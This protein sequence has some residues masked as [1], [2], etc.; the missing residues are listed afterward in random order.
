MRLLYIICIILHHR[1][2]IY[3]YIYFG[4]EMCNCVC[5][6]VQPRP[7]YHAHTPT[8]TD[9]C[10]HN[11]QLYMHIVKGGHQ[12]VTSL[13]RYFVIP[14]LCYSVTPLL[15]YSVTAL[16]R[17]SVTHEVIFLSND[18]TDRYFLFSVTDRVTEVT[19]LVRYSAT[20]CS[21]TPLLHYFVTQLT[22]FIVLIFF[23]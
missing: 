6:F 7:L 12:S 4:M 10:T 17:Y 13:L 9:A 11:M 5:T 23:W 22:P 14:L 18:V 20:F 3:L 15:R 19:F 21:V 2:Q 16:L 8:R 1:L